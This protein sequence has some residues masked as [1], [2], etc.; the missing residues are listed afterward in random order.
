MVIPVPSTQGKEGSITDATKIVSAAAAPLPV[1]Q[2]PPPQ[3]IALKRSR[4]VSTNNNGGAGAGGAGSDSDPDCAELE[5]RW[6]IDQKTDTIELKSSWFVTPSGDEK[7]QAVVRVAATPPEAAVIP[8]MFYM[9][10]Q[11]N[12]VR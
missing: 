1:S 12:Q 11:R 4:V 3:K 8:F 7:R 5:T 9:I 6:V 10:D 2:P